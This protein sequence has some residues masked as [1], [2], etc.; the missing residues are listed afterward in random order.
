M[1]HLLEKI[2]LVTLVLLLFSLILHNIKDNNHP[3]KGEYELLKTSIGDLCTNG[4]G[5]LIEIQNH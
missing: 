5:T 2:S 1:N 4:K 3:C